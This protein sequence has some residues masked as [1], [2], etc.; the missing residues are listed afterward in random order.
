[1]NKCGDCGIDFV[2]CHWYGPNF[3]HF[4]AHINSVH[5][6]FPNKKIWVNEFAL[7]GSPSESAQLG[8]YRQ[9]S[10]YLNSLGFVERYAWFGAFRGHSGN[11]MISDHGALTSL[12]HTY[13]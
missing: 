9:A 10:S 4:K 13:N 12:G 7:E 8:F 3:E 5:Q 2:A 1:M 6:A 11:N